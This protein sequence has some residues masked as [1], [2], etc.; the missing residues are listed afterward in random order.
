M[1]FLIDDG[2]PV[3]YTGN[4]GDAVIPAGVTEIGD[5]AFF[6]RTDL[7]SVTIPD[8][9]EEIG[10]GAFAG[11]NRLKS[12]TIPNSIIEICDGA[13][14]NCIGLTNVTFPAQVF[15]IGARAFAGCTAL[16]SIE[17]VEISAEGYHT[18]CC[19][20]IIQDAAFSG[21]KNLESV[22]IPACVRIE[23]VDAFDGCTNLVLKVHAGSRAE[24]CARENGIK[25]V[26]V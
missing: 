25:Y 5:W 24:R 1:E 8:G 3:E 18:I 15:L 6:D 20:V 9:V 19:D 14:E 11:C 17:I 26:C 16:K 4:G 21:C 2:K 7:T 23:G 10:R 12:V 13:F 22:T